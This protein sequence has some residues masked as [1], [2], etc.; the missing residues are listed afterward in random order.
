[1]TRCG[2]STSGLARL[3][4]T[5]AGFVDR[6]ELPG[7]VTLVARRDDVHVD[8]IGKQA[9]GSS[10]PMDRHTIFRI[11]SLTKPVAAA[12]AMILVE[13]CRLRLDDPI[14]PIVPELANRRVLARVDGPVEDT[15]PAR[16]SITTR[17]L[18]TLR[19]GFG[20]LMTERQDLPNPRGRTAR[21]DLARPAQT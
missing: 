14:D 17:D 7:L 13:E 18:L 10:A 16:Q 4:E 12:A 9:F 19:L 15:V 2:L 1:M 6:G 8:A 5:M 20:H 3:H 11:A 21:G